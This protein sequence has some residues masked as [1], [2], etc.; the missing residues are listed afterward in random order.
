MLGLVE[1]TNPEEYQIWDSQNRPVITDAELTSIASLQA[2]AQRMFEEEQSRVREPFS[3]ERLHPSNTEPDG[4]MMPP[5][6]ESRDYAS[7]E[8]RQLEIQR[9]RQ[10]RQDLRRM[11]RRHPAP[12]PPY[13]DNDPASMTRPGTDSPRPS[14]LTPALSPLRQLSGDS[15]PRRPLEESEFTFTSRDSLYGADVSIFVSFAIML[16][17]FLKQMCLYTCSVLYMSLEY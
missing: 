12:T 4:P 9:L 3:F 15:S 5:V 2:R 10:A 16:L 1:R 8:A 6:P 14:S 13:T 11:A 17:L 7:I